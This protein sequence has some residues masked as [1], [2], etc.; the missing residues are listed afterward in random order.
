MS[1]EDIELVRKG[2]D[3]FIAGDMVWLN[4]HLHEN[5]VW[6][7]PGSS[8]LAGEYHGR[9]QSLAFLAKSVQVAI[10]EFAIH[11][12]AVG[13]DHVVTLL[14]ATW[15]RPDGATFDSK[16]VQVF[17]VANGKA[18]ESWFFTEDQAGLDAFLEAA[19]T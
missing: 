11:D 10:P 6:H 15:R 12:L 14:D 7:M 18:L 17:H 4:E 13:E 19:T 2:Y 9:E 3:A 16:A 8:S 1:K 5:I